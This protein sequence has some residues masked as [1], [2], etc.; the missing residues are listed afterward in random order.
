MK[1]RRGLPAMRS[2]AQVASEHSR[3]MLLAGPEA[4]AMRREEKG[5]E[6]R[7]GP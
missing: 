3:K 1:E 4:V 7:R 6:L 2:S 5:E